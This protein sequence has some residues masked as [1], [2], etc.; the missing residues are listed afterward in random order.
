MDLARWLVGALAVGLLALTGC[1][2]GSRTSS[3][4]LTEAREAAVEQEVRDFVALVAR[5]V[6]EEGPRAWQ[7]HLADDPAFFMA[8][9]GKVQFPNRQSAREGI[10]SLAHTFV[11]I[12]LNWGDDLRIDPL[13]GDLAQVATSW[14][15]FLL[16]KDG[17]RTEVSGFLTGLAE[18]HNGQWQFR[19]QHWSVAAPTP[20]AP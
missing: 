19:N 5:D 15:E 7:K 11:H 13:T 20:Q 2:L 8:E 14:H 3:A 16:D 4:P 12:Q 18:R 6:T 1:G 9:D 10:E 17:H